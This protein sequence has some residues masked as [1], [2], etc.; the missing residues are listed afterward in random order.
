[1]DL[2]LEVGDAPGKIVDGPLLGNLGGG[3]L[4]IQPFTGGKGF[5][6]PRELK[7]EGREAAVQPIQPPLY[8]LKPPLHLSD[9]PVYVF[10][11]CP[12]GSEEHF[13]VRA[14]EGAYLFQIL[15]GQHNGV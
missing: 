14:N 10:F 5:A 4:A 6:D 3:Q 7:L 1:M 15:R 9:A 11:N 12:H 13:I 8:L 2:A